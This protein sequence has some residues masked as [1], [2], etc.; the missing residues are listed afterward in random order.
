MKPLKI[1]LFVKKSLFIV[2][3]NDWYVEY[4]FLRLLHVV[5]DFYVFFNTEI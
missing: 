2:M 4:Y 3:F 1:I 5:N